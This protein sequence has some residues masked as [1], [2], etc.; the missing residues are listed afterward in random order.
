M[1]RCALKKTR[2]LVSFLL[3]FSILLYAG[4]AQS[5]TDREQEIRD[6][7][8][9][10]VAKR[11]DGMGW[12]VRIRRINIQGALNTPEG[13]IDY[14]VVV[15]K[16]WQGWGNASI[17]V[18]ARKNGRV[19]QNLTVRVDVE[20]LAE[21]VVTRHQIDRGSIVSVDDVVLQKQEITQS[22]YL[23]ARTVDE[24]VGKKTRVTIRANQ[25]VRSDQLEKVPLIKSGQLVTIIA[26]TSVL[27]ISVS[28]KAN[29]SGAEGDIIRV[30]N[31]TSH[32]EIPAKVLNST[33]V[34]IA[35]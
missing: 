26:E 29:S 30:Q 12:D 19:V 21:A 14:E 16:Q 11:T 5:A 23:A 15:P 1:V 33:T 4:T 17:S 31:L 27:K 35:L 32:K 7:V 24:V 18:L 2:C 28:G 3:L 9:S 10:F 34:Q 25:A 20:A 6:I 13:S 8:T 22:S